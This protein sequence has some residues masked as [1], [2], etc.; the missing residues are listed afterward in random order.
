MNTYSRLA[1]S[2]LDGLPLQ[3]GA[4]DYSQS[5]I[6]MFSGDTGGAFVTLSVYEHADADCAFDP[7][8]SNRRFPTIANLPVLGTV[9]A[10]G[11]TRESIE[12]I[13]PDCLVPPVGEEVRIDLR[14]VVTL[15]LGPAIDMG[16]TQPPPDLDQLSR[17][18]AGTAAP[19]ILGGDKPLTRKNGEM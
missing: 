1:V 15:S 3:D 6:P 19:G 8:S 7:L 4:F 10:A 12:V 5:D 9:I 14:H 16:R 11:P 2:R 17:T 18:Y 13:I